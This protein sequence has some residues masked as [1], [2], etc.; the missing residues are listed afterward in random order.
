[1]MSGS[2]ALDAEKVDVGE[3]R[4]AGD[5]T[6][7]TRN[8]KLLPG[9]DTS[10]SEAACDHEVAEDFEAGDVY[11]SLRA[12]NGE[13]RTRVRVPL[14]LLRAHSPVLSAAFRNGWQEA[15]RR[16]VDVVGHSLSTLKRAVHYMHF[17]TLRDWDAEQ[18][19]LPDMTQGI[20]VAAQ[21]DLRDITTLYHFAHV[22]GL[23]ALQ[24]TALMAMQLKLHGIDSLSV[25]SWF[26][27]NL[28]K[29]LP[30][31]DGLVRTLVRW[32]V[33][34]STLS[35]SNNGQ[36]NWSNFDKPTLVLFCR[37]LSDRGRLEY[38]P[39]W[40]EYHGHDQS[41]AAS[42]DPTPCREAYYKIRDRLAASSRDDGL[43]H[44]RP[45]EGQ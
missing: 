17:R 9:E 38:G 24:L 22:Y 20:D 8:G 43:D 23:E 19:L 21:S 18:G 42:S 29:V 6:E 2:S 31:T 33:D 12:V 32:Y 37:A 13:D 16:Q 10:V 25:P 27:P 7:G 41:K 1:M 35:S 15:R 14:R 39:R 45:L 5:A 30:E 11:V 26:L 4:C 3:E 28:L 44:L 40:C 34:K 36:G